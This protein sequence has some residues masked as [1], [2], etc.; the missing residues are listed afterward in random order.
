[1]ENR[2]HLGN[3]LFFTLAPFATLV[4]LPTYVYLHGVSWGLFVFF[5]VSFA[6]TNLSITC[7]YH[8][9][10]SHRSYKARRAL[11][12]IY[13]FIGTGAIQGSVL[14]WSADHRKHHQKVDTSE[15]PYNIRKRFWWAH[16]GWILHARPRTDYHKYVPDLMKDPVLMFQDRHYITLATIVGFGLPTAIGLVLGY[17]WGGLVFGALLRIVV[18]QHTTFL[19]NSVAHTYGKQPYYK[20]NSARDSVLVSLLTF[21]E[22]FHN[23]HHRWPA[24]FRNGV[25][26]YDWDPTKWLL[27]LGSY[28]GLT[29][30][31]K[32]VPAS[33]ILKAEMKEKRRHSLADDISLQRHRNSLIGLELR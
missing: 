33:E 13:I 3:L 21:G 22:G 6:L 24:D 7:G 15:D 16:L 19:V 25:R 29:Y 12:L 11:E 10:F 31:L 2:F 17:G 27:V 4:L 5:A 30:D 32:R 28:C 14:L 9:Y 20:G 18:S 23:F 8:R 26:W 1:M